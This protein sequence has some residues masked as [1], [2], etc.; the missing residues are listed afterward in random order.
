VIESD[1]DTRHLLAD[2]LTDGGFIVESAAEVQS[3]SS[4]WQGDVILTDTFGSP[5]RVTAAARTVLDLKAHYR[6]PVVVVCGRGEVKNS[7]RGLAADAVIEKPFEVD[8]LL[9]TVR[10]VIAA[11]RE[12]RGAIQ[13]R[14]VS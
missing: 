13:L 7:G 1:P 11:S 8:A 10:N 4:H 2:V 12:R 9:A 6:A 3:L 14:D 5:F